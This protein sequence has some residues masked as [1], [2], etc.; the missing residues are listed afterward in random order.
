VGGQRKQLN[1][2]AVAVEAHPAET[3][4]LRWPFR[5]VQLK[6]DWPLVWAVLGQAL[7]HFLLWREVPAEGCSCHSPY[8]WLGGMN[9]WAL[10]KDL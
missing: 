4:E 1:C 8:S 6:P 10:K 5:V 3:W 2:R 9:A 7:R